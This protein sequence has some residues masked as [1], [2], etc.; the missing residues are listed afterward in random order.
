MS[1]SQMTF[2]TKDYMIFLLFYTFHYTFLTPREM[3][4]IRA[5]DCVRER[6]D[7]VHCFKYIFD[8]FL[9]PA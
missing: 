9:Y 8:T 6:K 7:G 1:T 3:I 5:V 2:E 4:P